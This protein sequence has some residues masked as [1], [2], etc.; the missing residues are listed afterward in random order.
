MEEEWV[1]NECIRVGV[2]VSIDG[3]SGV[4]RSGS[5]VEWCVCVCGLGLSVCEFDLN[6]IGVV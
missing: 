1:M 4:S 2:C 3:I 6:F 5:G